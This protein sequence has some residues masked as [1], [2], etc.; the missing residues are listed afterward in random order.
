MDTMDYDQE[1]IQVETRNVKY[2]GGH[3]T[4]FVSSEAFYETFK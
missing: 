4:E 3:G 1:N 2:L